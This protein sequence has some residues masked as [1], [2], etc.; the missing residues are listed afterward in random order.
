MKTATRVDEDRAKAEQDRATTFA[1]MEADR[2][3]TFARQDADRHLA[4]RTLQHRKQLEMLKLQQQY[5]GGNV[6]DRSTILEHGV[7]DHPIQ[8]D[9]HDYVEYG[10]GAEDQKHVGTHARGENKIKSKNAQDQPSTAGQL[11]GGGL[12]FPQDRGGSFQINFN[13]QR[14][15]EVALKKG[16]FRYNLRKE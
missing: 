8:H 2:V 3:T 7:G 15:P 10:W 5:L 16:D 4:R 13:A 11:G 1:R 6:T 9:Q 14:T 12:I